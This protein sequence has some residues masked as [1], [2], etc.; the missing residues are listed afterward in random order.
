MRI[1]KWMILSLFLMGCSSPETN[2]TVEPVEETNEIISV[3]ITE[4]DDIDQKY[5]YGSSNE[6]ELE[7]VNSMLST[8]TQMDGIVDMIDP[9]YKMVVEWEDDESETYSI[10]WQED[11]TQLSLMNW[12]DTHTVFRLEG[13]SARQFKELIK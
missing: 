9:N 13:E 2:E 1:G 5:L 11:P 6:S 8:A 4:T 10:W 7:I 3:V 12:V